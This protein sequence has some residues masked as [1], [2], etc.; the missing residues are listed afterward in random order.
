MRVDLSKYF[1]LRISAF[2]VGKMILC[3]LIVIA[4]NLAAQS[5][6]PDRATAGNC[7]GATVATPSSLCTGSTT[8]LSLS[9][10]DVFADTYQWYLNGVVIAGATSSTYTT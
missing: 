9:G 1:G 6:S 10:N 4:N 7:G 8:T 2:N 5:P 3:C